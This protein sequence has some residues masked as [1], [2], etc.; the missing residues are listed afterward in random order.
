[1]FKAITP[2]KLLHIFFISRIMLSS[3]KNSPMIKSFP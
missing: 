2:G 3:I 1:L